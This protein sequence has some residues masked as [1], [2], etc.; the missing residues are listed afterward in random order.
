MHVHVGFGVK[1]TNDQKERMAGIFANRMAMQ[2]VHVA[3]ESP[4]Y[5][6][7]ANSAC[8]EEYVAI[9]FSA[10]KYS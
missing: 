7:T 9:A 6:T 4:R 1:S 3:L 2:G 8:Y 5:S 10:G